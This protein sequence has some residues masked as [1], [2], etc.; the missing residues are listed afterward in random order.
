MCAR[1]M[2]SV[3]IAFPWCLNVALRQQTPWQ[4]GVNLGLLKAA[5]SQKHAHL[6][7]SMEE[8]RVHAQGVAACSDVL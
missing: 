1:H 6:A 3:H 8:S 2:L 4:M 7:C 5:G